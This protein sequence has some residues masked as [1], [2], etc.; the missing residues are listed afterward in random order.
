MYPTSSQESNINFSQES[1][2]NFS[3]CNEDSCTSLSNS[4]EKEYRKRYATLSFDG[5]NELE[6]TRAGVYLIRDD[7]E[8][9]SKIGC[10]FCKYGMRIVDA[11]AKKPVWCT[12]RYPKI[13]KTW[14]P[15]NPTRLDKDTRKRN[16]DD[17]DCIEFRKDYIS[18]HI[19]GR[20]KRPSGLHKKEWK[21]YSRF[22]ARCTDCELIDFWKKMEEKR[23]HYGLGH[24]F[25]KE[26]DTLTASVSEKNVGGEDAMRKM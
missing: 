3:S 6:F 11:S 24:Y 17:I 4:K 20:P 8:T 23:K 5:T 9:V 25:S 13:L 26:K 19:R 16:R 7:D 14:L 2:I 21:W 18:E 12:P 15:F 10:L 22:Q 1:N